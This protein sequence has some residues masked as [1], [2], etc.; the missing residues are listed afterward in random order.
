M[1]LIK[2]LVLLIS[3]GLISAE[4]SRSLSTCKDSRGKFIIFNEENQKKNCQ[5]IRNNQDNHYCFRSEEVRNNCQKTCKTGD[6]DKRGKFEM[7]LN[8]IKRNCQFVRNQA[9]GLCN[10]QVVMDKCPK[11]CGICPN[12]DIINEDIINDHVDEV[13]TC[14]NKRETKFR[15][16]VFGTNRKGRFRRGMCSE[17]GVIYNKDEACESRTVRKFCEKTC[18]LC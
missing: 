5:Y 3:F 18:D 11:T 10:V 8:T 2:N 12:E 1:K 13:D 15:S 17:I 9:I 14:A 7:T 6:T 16:R 4:S